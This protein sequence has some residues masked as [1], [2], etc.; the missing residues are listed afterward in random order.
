MEKKKNILIATDFNDLSLNASL[1]FCKFLFK[2]ST[3]NYFLLHVTEEVGFFGKLFGQQEECPDCQ[4]FRFDELKKNIKILYGLDVETYVR[5]GRISSEINNFCKE[6][7]I[8]LIVAGTS[9]SCDNTIGANT[10]RLIRTTD[11]PLMTI[12][13]NIDPKPIRNILLPIELMLS[14][15]QK[16]KDAISW[17]KAYGAKITILS[18]IWEKTEN[19]TY[20]KIITIAHSTQDFILNKGIDCEVVMLKDL[21]ESKD[22]ADGVINYMNDEKNQVDLTIVMGRDE[23]TDFSA[24]P[25][26]QDVVRFAKVPVV[27]VPLKKSGMSANFL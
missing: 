9:N 23:T 11:Y 21:N 6:K 27:C 25:R 20:K 18:G 14:S 7:D 22:Y 17:A 16:V 19:D 5:K 8:E 10:H 4:Q 1:K 12:N 26:S 24:D 13:M 3:T 15:R 2:D